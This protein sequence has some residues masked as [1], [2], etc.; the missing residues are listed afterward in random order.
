LLQAASSPVGNNFLHAG[1]S[2]TQKNRIR[3][4]QGFLGMEHG[5]DTAEDDFFSQAAIFIG[6]GPASLDLR[7]QHHRDSYEITV[8]F[9]VKVLDILI[10]K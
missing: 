9:K 3:V 6:N 5:C 7:T 10:D 1:F 2:F 4:L 8:I